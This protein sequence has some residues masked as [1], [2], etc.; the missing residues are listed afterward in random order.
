M[1]R[2]I[3]VLLRTISTTQC[4]PQFFN[5]PMKQASLLHVDFFTWD[6]GTGERSPVLTS[7][8]FIHDI[9]V[10]HVCKTGCLNNQVFLAPPLLHIRIHIHQAMTLAREPDRILASFQVD[11]Y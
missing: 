9:S 7:T 4:S 2:C 8:P 5:F 1:G 3:G 11:E 6:Y 10:H